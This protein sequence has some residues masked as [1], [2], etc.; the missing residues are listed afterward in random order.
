[1]ATPN[2]PSLSPEAIHPSDV[3]FYKLRLYIEEHFRALPDSMQLLS[4]HLEPDSICPYYL[5]HRICPSLFSDHICQATYHPEFVVR[6][7]HIQWLPRTWICRAL[8]RHLANLHTS[9]CPIPQ[10]L[11]SH[12]GNWAAAEQLAFRAL[13]LRT[14]AHNM[15]LLWYEQPEDSGLHP[16]YQTSSP[17]ALR[18]V[19]AQ[20]FIT[21]EQWRYNRDIPSPPTYGPEPSDVRIIQRTQHLRRSTTPRRNRSPTP[22]R[23]EHQHR[24]Q[25]LVPE[26]ARD[27][28]P[29]RRN[30]EQPSSSNR[31]HSATRNKIGHK[32]A[33]PQPP[34]LHSTHW[35]PD[36]TPFSWHRSIWRRQWWTRTSTS[37]FTDQPTS[38]QGSATTAN[39]LPTT[40]P[41][42]HTGQH[43]ELPAESNHRRRQQLPHWRNPSSIHATPLPFSTRRTISYQQPSHNL[44]T[45]QRHFTPAQ[46]CQHPTSDK[47]HTP[48]HDPLG[49]FHTDANAHT[50]RPIHTHWTGTNNTIRNTNSQPRTG[51][52]TVVIPPT[53]HPRQTSCN[54]GLF[55]W[56]TTRP[57]HRASLILQRS[58][59]RLDHHS[60]RPLPHHHQPPDDSSQSNNAEHGTDDPHNNQRQYH[61][62]GPTHG[63]RPKHRTQFHWR[64]L[65]HLTRV[66][67][68][69]E[70][71]ILVS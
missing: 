67:R 19:Q 9:Q 45:P 57:K 37:T 54:T 15:G 12:A 6:D 49:S 8:Q 62:T 60:S 35:V 7:G 53:H 14:Q 59:T 26:T 16:L 40:S 2:S 33:P 18:V 44:A 29:P 68:D 70:H 39:R 27:I 31:A 30:V 3:D 11:Y 52:H 50:K 51:N 42:T 71:P 17:T 28:T 5:S 69:S 32:A 34:A 25:Q 61:T 58:S 4:Q 48:F 1:M 20:P 46:Q 63:V 43:P 22:V 41:T 65:F 10:C 21:L 13:A 47:H 66:L 55:D 38:A 36:T 24:P 64:A 23:R 56:I